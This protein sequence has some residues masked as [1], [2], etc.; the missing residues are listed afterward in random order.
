MR[1]IELFER[2]EKFDFLQATF[3]FPLN[4][5]SISFL[6]Q[7]R[8]DK[9][10]ARRNVPPHS[11]STRAQNSEGGLAGLGTYF[12]RGLPRLDAIHSHSIVD[13]L[14]ALASLLF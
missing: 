2:F 13:A 9:K 8:G 1:E 6:V 14:L 7:K 5:T 10:A 4:K 3:R 12:F 11:L